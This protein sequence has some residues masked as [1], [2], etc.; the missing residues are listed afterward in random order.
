LT[1]TGKRDTEGQKA[2]FT[3]DTHFV[4]YMD[5]QGSEPTQVLDGRE[6]RTPVFDALNNYQGP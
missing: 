4:I 1:G 2:P 3:E 5:G 6:G